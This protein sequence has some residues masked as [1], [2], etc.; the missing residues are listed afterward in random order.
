MGGWPSGHGWI[1]IAASFLLDKGYVVHGIK[2]RSSSF[3]TARNS[4]QNGV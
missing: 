2:W 3:N 1:G 4:R